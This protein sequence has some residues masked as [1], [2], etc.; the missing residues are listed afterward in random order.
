MNAEPGASSNLSSLVNLTS[1]ADLA[2]RVGLNLQPGQ[3]L[4]I[5]GPL[6]TGGVSLEAA[7]FVREIA[8]SAY[9][10]GARMVEALWGDEPLLM[11]RFRHA[12]RESF[13]EFSRWLPAALAE[14]ADNGDAIL[15]VYANDPDQLQGEDLQRITAL[16]HST[17]RAVRPFRD[18]ISRNDTNWTVV[19]AAAPAWARK[20][21]PGLDDATATARL[22]EAIARLCR[23]DQ[24]DPVE[25]WRGHLDALTMRKDRL[26][27]SRYTALKYTG[28]GTELTIGLPDS[29]LWVSGQSANRAGVMFAPNVPTEEVFTMPHKDQVDGVVSSTKPLSYGGT[30]IEEFRLEF[31]AGRVV[32]A[33]AAKGEDVLRD[34]VATDEGAARLGEIALVAHST[35][36]SQSGL[37]FYNTLFD[38]NAASHVAL[39]SAYRF[40]YSGGEQMTEEAFEAAGG[41]RSAIHV[42]FMIGSGAL[43]VDG[44]RP[45]GA[46]E[47][48]MRAGEWVE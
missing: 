41:N 43:D 16:Q 1:Y 10:A 13:D 5:I 14:H 9:R 23:L 36:I 47:P 15:S 6:A 3:R 22:W 42:D 32:R 2:V 25:A 35:P 19:A 45:D 8:A 34:L 21:F 30:L 7:P 46:A 24:P 18:R 31:A 26:N 17:A 27:R 39:G 40:T 38:E 12:P 11:A 4:M 44:V 33:S 28:P 29:H 48:L 37:L 20:V